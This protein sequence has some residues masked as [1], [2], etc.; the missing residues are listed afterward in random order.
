[1]LTWSLGS[2]R[3]G[4]NTKS[5]WGNERN[6]AKGNTA[7]RA[8]LSVHL[9]PPLRCLSRCLM[10]YYG[11]PK[12]FTLRSKLALR[13]QLQSTFLTG[14][15][16]R[17][18]HASYSFGL[19]IAHNEF[20]IIVSWNHPEGLKGHFKWNIHC[21]ALQQW[22]LHSRWMVPYRS[23]FMSYQTNTLLDEIEKR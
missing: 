13:P 4:I 14:A 18:S 10:V 6:R 7:R 12:V 9:S 1:M 8:A 20:I 11:K 5:A 22:N 16:F 17:S 2:Y 15:Q 19:L 3:V 23:Q 21:D